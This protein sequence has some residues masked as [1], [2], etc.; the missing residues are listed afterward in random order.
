[1]GAGGKKIAGGSKV[2]SYQISAIGNQP[3]GSLVGRRI[4]IT[5]GML[6]DFQLPLPLG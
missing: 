1:M 3:F 2:I 5:S 6:R 4:E